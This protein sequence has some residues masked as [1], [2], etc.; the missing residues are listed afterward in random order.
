MSTSLR[1]Q[2]SCLQIAVAVP[3]SLFLSNTRT[4]EICLGVSEPLSLAVNIVWFA[5]PRHNRQQDQTSVGTTA[6]VASR[7]WLSSSS[8]GHAFTY[9]RAASCINAKIWW[10]CPS[11]RGSRTVA[12]QCSLTRNSEGAGPSRRHRRLRKSA[13][14]RT[15]LKRYLHFHPLVLL[16]HF[17]IALFCFLSCGQRLYRS[18][19]L[20]ISFI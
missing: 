13:E 9:V 12:I 15:T 5:Q 11:P 3:L 17:S 19:V 16:P 1:N 10:C 2:S 7:H 18:H 8:P 6:F 4:T 14:T 20:P